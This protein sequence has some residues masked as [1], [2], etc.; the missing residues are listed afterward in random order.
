MMKFLKIFV[1]AGLIFGN[2]FSLLAQ[3]NPA[4]INGRTGQ[5]LRYAMPILTV[6]NDSRAAAMG[7][8]GVATSPDANSQHWNPAKFAF[9][10]SDMGFSISYTPWLNSLASDMSLNYLTGYKRL[11]NKQA[12]SASLMFFTLGNITFTDD[13]GETIKPFSPYEFAIDGSYIRKLSD[14]FSSSI[15]FRYIHSNLAGNMSQENINMSVGHSVAAD[16]GMF[17]S[18]PLKIDKND[19]NIAAGLSISNLGDKM[20]Y[21]SAESFLPTNLRLGSA[22]TYDMDSY[23]QI[24]FAIDFNKLLVPTPPHYDQDG[25]MIGG[26]DPNVGVMRGLFQ[27]FYDAPGGFNEELREVAYSA[28]VEYMYYQQFAVRCG[29]FHE[30]LHKGNRKYFTF[31]AGLKYNV[32]TLDFSYLVP[33][34][35][36]VDNPLKNTM[37]FTLTF[38]FDAYKKQRN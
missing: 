20:S 15:S 36:S 10:D 24:S 32:F 1:F 7:D 26:M 4:E 37:R 6:A 5:S 34:S 35:A 16:I 2:T 28:G 3:L 23:N 18:Q 11:D 19:A 9:I 33:T 21:S 14:M 31:G 13:N 8:V 38:D 22:F 12:I 29:Y 25:I 27:S 30:D 17:Y